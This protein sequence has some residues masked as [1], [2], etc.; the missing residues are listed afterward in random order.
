[1]RED[2]G[3]VIAANGSFQFRARCYECRRWA[4][5]SIAHAYV[6][7]LG[8]R[9]TDI[10]V[11]RDARGYLAICSVRGCGSD[12]V[13]LNHFAP[14]AIFGTQADEWPTAFLCRKHHQEWGQRVTPQLNP[15]A[16][17]RTS[18]I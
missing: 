11:I 9:F 17:L 6:Y 4:S 10:E 2:L 15:P 16:K 3:V 13:E 8:L 1:V 12:D 7:S 5:S 14:R 18:G